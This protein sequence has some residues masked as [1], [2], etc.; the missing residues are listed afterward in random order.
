MRRIVWLECQEVCRHCKAPIPAGTRAVRLEPAPFVDHSHLACYASRFRIPPSEAAESFS[1][2]KVGEG[3][4]DTCAW[5]LASSPE[6]DNLTEGDPTTV[7]SR[8][9]NPSARPRRAVMESL[10]PTGESTTALAGARRSAQ[11]I[12]AA[13]T[14]LARDAG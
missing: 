9:M 4:S 14:R 3:A 5:L 12:A 6:G 8:R 13:P 7:I 1:R 10:P 11:P 2:E